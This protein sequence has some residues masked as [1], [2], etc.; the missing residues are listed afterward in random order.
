[1]ATRRFEL[2][3]PLGSTRQLGFPWHCDYI[4]QV[5]SFAKRARPPRDIDLYLIESDGF[6]PF[7]PV[8]RPGHLVNRVPKDAD[9]EAGN[10]GRLSK[11][12]GCPKQK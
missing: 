10:S 2:G 12:P 8:I 6:Q 9:A 1:M 5:Q 3:P 11:R 4:D 7:Q